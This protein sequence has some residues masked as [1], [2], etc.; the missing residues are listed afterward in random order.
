MHDVDDELMKEFE[1]IRRGGDGIKTREERG[2][3]GESEE[4]ET[5][6]N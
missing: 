3:N 1:K 2:K 5:A 6:N 4:N